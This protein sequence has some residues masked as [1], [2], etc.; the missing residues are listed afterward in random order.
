MRNAQE[1][2]QLP[3][4]RV[5]VLVLIIKDSFDFI[6]F[7]AYRHVKMEIGFR[8][9]FPISSF[10]WQEQSVAHLI[11]PSWQ[12]T[13]PT[14]DSLGANR[15]FHNTLLLLLYSQNKFPNNSSRF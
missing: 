12:S 10:A 13:R 6:F 15:K 1:L 5:Q 11:I 14:L 2:W 9:V 3:L 8:L 7:G 4:L